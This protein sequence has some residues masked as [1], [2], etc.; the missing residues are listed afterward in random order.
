MFKTIRFTLFACL[1]ASSAL[2]LPACDEYIADSAPSP[3]GSR[4]QRH[5]S[6]N[7]GAAPIGRPAV[8][9]RRLGAAEA[10]RR[11]NSP[12]PID[13]IDVRSELERSVSGNIPGDIN[14]PLQPENEFIYR[15]QRT[16]PE[17]N[18]TIFLYCKSG[19]MSDR[20]GALLSGLGYT[21]VYLLGGYDNWPYK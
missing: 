9:P 15:V 14:I 12:E 16:I 17:R 5:L 11:L 18:A 19:Q 13:L 3:S 10:N 8:A 20:A 1:L 6:T 21:N 7:L 4:S 2:L